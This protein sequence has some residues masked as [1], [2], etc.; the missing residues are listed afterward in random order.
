MGH[1]RTYEAEICRE[2][3][4]VPFSLCDRPPIRQGS[5]NACFAQD[6]LLPRTCPF[7]DVAHSM[8]GRQGRQAELSMA[9]LFARAHTQWLRTLLVRMSAKFLSG[10]LFHLGQGL[11]SVR[12]LQFAQCVP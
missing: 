9:L 2:A 3:G 12:Q 5:G 4:F 11:R 7:R 10:V 6:W 8:C 1:L